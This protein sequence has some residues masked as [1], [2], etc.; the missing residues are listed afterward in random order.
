MAQ[1]HVATEVPEPD[2]AR[3]GQYKALNVQN[4]GDVIGADFKG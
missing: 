4:Y 2:D 3:L 1:T